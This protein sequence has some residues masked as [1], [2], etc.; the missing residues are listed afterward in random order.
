MTLQ[1]LSRATDLAGKIGAERVRHRLRPCESVDV[2]W[3]W[4]NTSPTVRTRSIVV[5]DAVAQRTT[6]PTLYVAL[7]ERLARQDK[8]EIILVGATTFG[9]EF[10]P[11]WPSASARVSPPTAWA[12]TSTRRDCSYRRPRHSAATCWPEIV[13]PEKQAPDGNGAAGDLPGDP[14]RLPGRPARS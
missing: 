5:E 3:V 11:G 12:W 7:M 13:T 8:P 4:A 6:P 14:P 2:E 9:R 1:L 10:A